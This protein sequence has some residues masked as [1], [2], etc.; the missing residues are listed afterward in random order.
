MSMARTLETWLRERGVDY[1]LIPHP[2]TLSSRETA[3]AAHVP[4][5][6]I[7]KAVIVRDA[8]GKFAMAVIPGDN[9]LRLHTLAEAGGREFVLAAEADVDALFP[10]CEPGA[11]PPIGPAYG[12]ETYVD[13]ALRSLA[14]VFF[15]AG[16][17]LELVRVDG[18]DFP[19]LVPDA[20]WGHFSHEE[21]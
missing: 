7:A 12:L 15:E 21:E 1:D 20:H 14:N 18:E 9:W 8:A 19:K 4:P 6:H 17:H 16:D 13:E 11:I 5:D 10:D 3:D 2:R